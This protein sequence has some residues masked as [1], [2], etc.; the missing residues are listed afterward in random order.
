MAAAPQLIQ[1]IPQAVVASRLVH[2]VGLRNLGNTCYMNT[3]VQALLS[4]PPFCA[5]IARNA[6]KSE[7]VMEFAQIYLHMAMPIV[8][9]PIDLAILAEKIIG[10]ELRMYCQE[11]AD[12]CFQRICDVL[13]ESTRARLAAAETLDSVFAVRY[14][15]ELL[16]RSCNHHTVGA[17]ATAVTQNWIDVP[18]VAEYGAV[19]GDRPITTADEFGQFLRSHRDHPV[20]FRCEAC[21][22]V[23][24]T[25]KIYKLAR[26]SPVCVMVFKKYHD[27][28]TQFFPQTFS[29]GSKSGSLMH[30]DIVAQIEQSGDM[31]GGHYYAIGRR[32]VPGGALDTYLLDD[33]YSERRPE[34]FVPSKNTYMVMYVR[35]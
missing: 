28:P 20:D 6:E 34:G 24:R 15:Y 1:Y 2:A 29:I 4:C 31:R 9:G 10:G 14:S 25:E 5:W 7:A 23:N 26:I 3:V 11:D 16:C 8:S 17:A 21:G 13:H 18:M 27:K 30:Y 22:S 35:R 19:A 32:I 12:A 33:S